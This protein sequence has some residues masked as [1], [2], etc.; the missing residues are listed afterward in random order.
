M[1]K[2]PEYSRQHTPQAV[3]APLSVAPHVAG[4]D[5]GLGQL[6]TVVGTGLKAMDLY[7]E[8]AK[9]EQAMAEN[10]SLSRMNTE[11]TLGAG[12]IRSQAREQFPDNPQAGL[13]FL[14]DT[15][16]EQAEARY[17]SLS[18][19]L[20]S[21]ALAGI[22]SLVTSQ[23]ASLSKEYVDTA[24]QRAENGT[25]DIFHGAQNLIAQAGSTQDLVSALSGFLSREELFRQ[26]EGAEKWHQRRNRIMESLSDGVMSVQ[27]KSG[28]AAAEGALETLA[29]NGFISG[30]EKDTLK[31]KMLAKANR[32]AE[33]ESDTYF[34]RTVGVNPE[35]E[36]AF[37]EGRYDDARGM[38]TAT[39]AGIQGRIDTL[40]AR[41]Q[42]G[43]VIAAEQQELK[44]LKQRLPLLRKIRDRI[45]GLD[46]DLTVNQAKAYLD[47]RGR[48]EQA[49]VDATDKKGDIDF[50]ELM[51][52]MRQ[53]NMEVEQ[54]FGEK[55][56]GLGD[57]RSL[58]GDIRKN[59]QEGRF[60]QRIDKV[61]GL[62]AFVGLG[63]ETNAIEGRFRRTLQADWKNLPE[64][65]KNAVVRMVFETVDSALE[66][67]PELDREIAIDSAVED[68]LAAAFG[69]GGA[70]DAE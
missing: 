52:K 21:R 38:V 33:I 53:L 55:K 27:S 41:R 69:Y 70:Q 8:T 43:R 15:L 17:S 12:E 48:F 61:G 50:V 20:Q 32:A 45:D 56:I 2:I 36:A 19:E 28:F 39:A 47:L 26:V 34:H 22:E 59:T 6:A 49:V 29:A 64:T 44:E 30:G 24:K 11:L 63:T 31:E 42:P 58:T 3:G 66:L 13:Q 40:E 57:F 18:P 25:A 23:A 62:K 16:R 5:R 54:A 10:V 46:P 60:R 35:L 67:D 1:V 68:I 4:P 14:T 37:R 65:D 7:V 51:P 9:R